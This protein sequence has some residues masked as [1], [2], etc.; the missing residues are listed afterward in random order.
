MF[1][2]RQPAYYGQLLEDKHIHERYFPGV[3]NRVFLELGAFDGITYSNTKFFEDT[4]GWTGVLIEAH[5]EA[6]RSLAW[7]RPHCKTYHYAV[8]TQ[9]TGVEFIVNVNGPVSSVKEFTSEKHQKA[10][11]DRGATTIVRVPSRPLGSILREADVT[12]IDFWS[13][14]VEGGELEVLKSMD[15]TIPVYLLCIET[16]EPDRKADC[17]AILKENG[18]QFVETLH[19]NEIW[20]NVANRPRI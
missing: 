13:L 11:H 12:R 18:F 20:V 10:W 4:L 7:N 2:L 1:R 8:S 16:Q 17:D 5:P 14:D 6:Y 3:R 19:H 9:D 15:W